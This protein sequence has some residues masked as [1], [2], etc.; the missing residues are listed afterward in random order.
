MNVANIDEVEVASNNG[1]S[2]ISDKSELISFQ[3][4]AK[5]YEKAKEEPTFFMSLRDLYA[6]C[7]NSIQRERIKKANWDPSSM[8]GTEYCGAFIKNA[9]P[10]CQLMS[11][12]VGFIFSEMGVIRK[13]IVVFSVIVCLQSLVIEY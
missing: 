4:L 10:M 12:K 1:S 2:G 13:V 11:S 9:F 7:T 5:I 6:N 3:E 8:R